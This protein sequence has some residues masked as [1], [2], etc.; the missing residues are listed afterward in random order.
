MFA[1]NPALT[2]RTIKS[3][4]NDRIGVSVVRRTDAGFALK[5]IFRLTARSRESFVMLA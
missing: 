3:T 4:I 1:L 2:F 5:N